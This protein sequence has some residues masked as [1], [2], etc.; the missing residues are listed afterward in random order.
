MSVA[1]GR[2]SLDK[3]PDTMVS[4]NISPGVLVSTRQI[5]DTV[6]ATQP[7]D[8]G[9]LLSP[10]IFANPAPL[11]LC[12][13]ALTSFTSGAV[14]ISSNDMTT[15][16]VVTASAFAYGGLVQILVGMWYILPFNVLLG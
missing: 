5:Q 3:D 6:P 12:A 9:R 8:L 7:I 16:D 10:R 4:E 13:F 11:G 2:A 15:P 1:T 14:Y